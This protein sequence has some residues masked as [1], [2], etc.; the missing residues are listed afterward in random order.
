MKFLRMLVVLMVSIAFVWP[1][2]SFAAPKGKV[3]LA[4]AGSVKTYDPHRITGFP[5]N[6]HYPLVFDRLLFR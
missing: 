3:V 1:A 6:S 5:L 4:F 2:N